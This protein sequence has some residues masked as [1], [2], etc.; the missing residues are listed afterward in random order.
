ME[1]AKNLSI[2]FNKSLQW[3]TH[4]NSVSGITFSVLRTLYLLQHITPPLNIRGLLAKTYLMPKLLY[5]LNTHINSV[6]G[7]TFSIHRKLYPLQHITPL[8]IRVL[9]AQT[10]LMPKLLYGCEIFAY[11][12]STSKSRSTVAY[13]ALLRY[14]Y[15]IRRYDGISQHSKSLYNVE[16]MDLLKIKALI[17]L[18]KVIYTQESSYLFNHIQLKHRTLISEWQFFTNTI[19][20]WNSLPNPLQITGSALQF[21]KMLFSNF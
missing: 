9:L 15:N 20:L 8:N 13:N 10:Y 14:V 12:D 16:L 19:R 6:S 4:I 7:I 5:Q 1:S 2:I 3:N 21:K 11:C 17:L 18:H